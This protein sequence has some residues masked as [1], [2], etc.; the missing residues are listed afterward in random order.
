[1]NELS[2]EVHAKH[3]SFR[4]YKPELF[5]DCIESLWIVETFAEEVDIVIPPNQF[6]DWI[7]LLNGKGYFHNESY[8]T[9]NRLE[10]IMLKPVYLKLPPYIKALGV[11]LYGNGL[12]PFVPLKGKDL[13][14]KNIAYANPDHKNLIREITAA[15]D[16]K[17]TISAT[18]QFLKQIHSDNREKESRL[19]KEFYLYMKSN[20]NC[21]DI[22]AFCDQTNT[23]YTSLNKSFSKI[24]GITAKKFERLIKFRKA[25]KALIN[26]PERLTDVVVDSGY[27][28]QSH[29]IKE[30][31]HYMDMSPSE[32]LN[33]LNS[34]SS[35]TIIKEIDLSVI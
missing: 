19:V 23:N 21:S 31:K 16:S 12:Y 25:I 11:R 35:H 18:Y 32:Y 10:G 26:S 33:L 22:R 1:M 5:E 2:I 8:I 28:D 20:E 30:F 4:N 6:I 3:L 7:F 14:N 17:S 13:I 9:E 34:T 29:F 24:L 15:P 27:F